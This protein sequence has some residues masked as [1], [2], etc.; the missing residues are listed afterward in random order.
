VPYGSPG[1]ADVV[2]GAH[3]LAAYL[4][5][6]LSDLAKVLPG[7]MSIIKQFVMESEIVI[8]SDRST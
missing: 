3:Y 7:Q 2:G 8:S 4:S 1:V 5:N 6:M